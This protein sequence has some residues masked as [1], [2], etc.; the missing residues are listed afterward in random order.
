MDL[1]LFGL[2]NDVPV[3]DIAAATGLTDEQV[4]RV[5]RDIEQ[6]RKTTEYLQLAPVLAA[7]VPEIGH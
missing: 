5:I 4:N 2:N 1:C 6:K 7:D 3:P